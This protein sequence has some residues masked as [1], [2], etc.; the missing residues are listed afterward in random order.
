MMNGEAP[1]APSMMARDRHV[2]IVDAI[3]SGDTA[4][5]TTVVHQHMAAAAD[6]YAPHDAAS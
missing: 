6:Q 1:G 4:A 2:P 5:A 3:E